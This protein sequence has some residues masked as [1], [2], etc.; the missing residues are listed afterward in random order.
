MFMVTAHSSVASKVCCGQ[1]FVLSVI[2]CRIRDT[3]SKSVSKSW[4]HGIVCLPFAHFLWHFGDA[5]GMDFYYSKQDDARKMVE[6]LMAVVPSR[7]VVLC[8][9]FLHPWRKCV[10]GPFFGEYCA[11]KHLWF[12][13]HR[14]S[15]V[16]LTLSVTPGPEVA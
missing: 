2:K 10:A 11:A 4:C 6:F 5:D 13:L 16:V 3:V 15:V 7:W 1:Q 9:V 8:L 12:Q 14:F